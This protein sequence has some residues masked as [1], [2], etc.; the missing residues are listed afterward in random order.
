LIGALFRLALNEGNIIIDNFEIH[1]LGL[2]ELR[3]KLTF[4]PQE[5]VLFSGTIRN[6]LDLYDEYSDHEIWSAL[7]EVNFYLLGIISFN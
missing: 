2:H 6:N 5:P 1:E 3:S 4:I 7:N